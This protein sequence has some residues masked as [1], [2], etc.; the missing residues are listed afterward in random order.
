MAF[1]LLGGQTVPSAK[2][3]IKKC[4][5]AA[6]NDWWSA[7]NGGEGARLNWLPRLEGTA[8]TMVR[9]RSI[10]PFD[11]RSIR[12]TKQVCHQLMDLLRPSDGLQYRATA[13]ITAA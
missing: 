4:L 5:A 7:I 9:V 11:P 13:A 12:R 3:A 1:T 2:I 10:Q 6:E 8:P